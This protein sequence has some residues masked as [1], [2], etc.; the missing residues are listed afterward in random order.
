MQ[1]HVFYTDTHAHTH[2]H[3]YT[4]AVFL[5]RVGVSTI[6]YMGDKILVPLSLYK[7]HSI[8]RQIAK[9][10]PHHPPRPQPLI[11]PIRRLKIAAHDSQP[12]TTLI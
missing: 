3:A 2:T 7:I 12:L 10:H 11:A 9:L 6:P 1:E 5:L 4:E 8:L